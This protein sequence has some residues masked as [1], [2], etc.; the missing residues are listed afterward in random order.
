MH[1]SID[2][3]IIT[4][5]L[6]LYQWIYVLL[7][8]MH[9]VISCTCMCMSVLVIHNNSTAT[10]TTTPAEI[11]SV[12]ILSWVVIV[13]LVAKWYLLLKLFVTIIIISQMRSKWRLQ[14]FL[15]CAAKSPNKG[16]S[17]SYCWRSHFRVYQCKLCAKLW[18]NQWT[19]LHCCHG[20]RLIIV[21][22]RPTIIS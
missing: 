19:K 18:W 8:V 1:T 5:S 22:R 4:C 20:V 11:F 17:W 3:R 16:I 21:P 6:R 7:N 9:G 2:T 12:T 13:S 10:F 14:S 15:G